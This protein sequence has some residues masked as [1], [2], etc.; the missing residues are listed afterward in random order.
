MKRVNNK[1]LNNSPP[2]DQQYC[3]IFIDNSN[4]FI[5][6]QKFYAH[7][8]KWIV[9]TDPTF[10]IDFG[11]MVLQ[12]ASGLK[13]LDIK[14]YGSEPPAL[15]TLWQ[16]LRKYQIDVKKFKRN[17]HNKEKEVDQQLVADAVEA[18][19]CNKDMCDIGTFIFVTGDRDMRSAITKALEYN[20]RV[21]V[22]SY[23]SALSNK[24]S[25]IVH[26]NLTTIHIDNIIYD[27]HYQSV[28]WIKK[29][30]PINS[31][32]IPFRCLISEDKLKSIAFIGAKTFRLPCM[33]HW[34]PERGLMHLVFVPFSR[35]DTGLYDFDHLYRTH[36]NNFRTN[37]D[38]Y[39]ASQS[40]DK[41]CYI[42]ISDT[43]SFRNRCSVDTSFYLNED[44]NKFKFL[45][46]DNYNLI[47][48][49]DENATT[50]QLLDCN[51]NV[52]ISEEE[53]EVEEEGASEI[54]SSKV[55]SDQVSLTGMKSSD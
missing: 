2:D 43:V 47:D 54:N 40:I 7:K 8:Q 33:Y 30:P 28:R 32:V 35:E 27:C 45:S 14:L 21:Y 31:I 46:N 26:P 29:V 17:I 52:L 3:W 22:F 18:V 49:D 55:S 1:M 53:D 12:V 37:I 13:I 44:L 41:S 38:N 25:S 4:L 16:Q 23:K 6:G 19:C 39:L 50:S 48:H 20:F 42:E 15:D 24:L 34:N 11:R 36:I 9:R 10:R 5:E 51:N